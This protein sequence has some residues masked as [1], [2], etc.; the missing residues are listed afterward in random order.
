MI[1]QNLTI[2]TMINV[3]LKKSVQVANIPTVENIQAKSGDY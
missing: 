2:D 1:E 3:K